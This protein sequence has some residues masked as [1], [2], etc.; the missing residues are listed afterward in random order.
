MSEGRVKPKVR[1]ERPPIQEVIC[2]LH[3]TLD[4]PLDQ[5]AI[6][7][8][9]LVWRTEYPNQQIVA[10]QNLELH[11]GMDRLDAKSVPLGHKLITR[12]EDGKSLAQLGPRFLA[13]NRL[14]PYLGWE[15]CFRDVILARLDE[16][17]AVY[18]FEDV[19]RIGLRYI[20][21]IDF[22]VKPVRWAEW[23]QVAM[24]VPGALG[25][26]GGS[27]QF[28]FE[29]EIG[30]DLRAIIN[31][32]CPPTPPTACTSVILD[33]DVIWS[34]RIKASSVRDTLES[35]HTPHRDLFEGYLL[36]KTRNLFQV[37]P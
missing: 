25:D 5:P 23:L 19:G 2:E 15:A 35:V 18:G 24:P 26:T 13:V 10:E 9:G 6:S 20:N 4:A 3:F 8:M 31:F 21:R 22:P 17:T 30:G 32:L 37:N 7:R 16:V 33:I 12:S 14:S 11:L 36:D 34:G 1:Y 27:F 28:H 29:H